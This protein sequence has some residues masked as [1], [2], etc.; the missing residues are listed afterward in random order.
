[1]RVR[2]PRLIVFARV[3]ILGRVKTRLAASI[4]DE[5]AL[6]VHRALLATTLERAVEASA[7]ELELCIDGEDRHGDCAALARAAGAVLR[8]QSGD[9]LGERMDEALK[10][11]LGEGCL[12]VLIG[13]DSPV[14]QPADLHAAFEA[15]AQADAV[16]SPAE[17]GGYALVGC[18]RPIAEAFRDID[19]GRPSVMADTRARLTDAGIGW[20]ELRTVWDVDEADDLRRWRTAGAGSTSRC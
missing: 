12:P 1:M 2:R 11:A 17:D 13:C 6:D 18:R 9:S 15:L 14:L 5:A 4:G 19:W 8:R 16:F 10:R 3:P 20:R 7:G